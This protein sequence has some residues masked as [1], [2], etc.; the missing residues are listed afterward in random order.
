M[1]IR[2]ISSEERLTASFPLLGYAFEHSP[3]TADRVEELRGYLPYN[4]GNVTL[5]AEENGT[6]VAVASAIPMR[7]NIRGA[8]VPM[9]GIAGVATHPLARRQGH[10]RRVLTR[11]LGEMRDEGFVATALYPFRPS[12]YERFGYVGFPMPRTVTVAP[13]DLASFLRL[14]LPGEITWQRIKDGYDSYR[15][16]T[17]RFLAERH[18][19]A[20]FPDFRAARQRDRNEEW[21]ITA[22]VDGETVAAVPYRISGHAQDLVAGDLLA[23]DPVARALV[24]QF[25]ARHVDQVERITMT[26]AADENPELWGTDLAA[27]TEAKIHFPGSSAPMARI[28][29]MPALTGIDAGPGRLTVEVVDDPFIAGSYLLDGE[30]GRLEVTP[31]DSPATATLTAAGISALVY[32]VLDPVEVVLRGF[33]AIPDAAAAT[34]RSLFPR[35]TPNLFAAF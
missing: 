31:T 18:G 2:R 30:S 12:F 26:V 28:L 24:L 3:G 13:A 21:L 8:V 25:F 19:F 27:H 32:G 15:A 20:V 5:A 23:T 29:S 22:V 4:E 1:T 16:F 6:A 34:L 7:Q 17:Q 14:D 35:R 11:L 10:V 33:G 9:A